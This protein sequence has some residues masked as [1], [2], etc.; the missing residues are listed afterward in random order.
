[1]N[2]MPLLAK[3]S[4][5]A[6]A[7]STVWPYFVGLVVVGVLVALLLI[8]LLP[9]LQRQKAL[10][11]ATEAAVGHVPRVRV[12]QP[13]VAPSTTAITLPGTL[14][15][16]RDTLIYARSSGYVRSWRVDLGD[17]VKAGDLLAEIDQPEVGHQLMQ[18]KAVLE[19]S[20]ANIEQAKVTVAQAM[21]NL[22]RQQ[23][24][25]P[26]M[27][28]QQEIDNAQTAYDAGRAAVAVAEAKAKGDEADVLR[29]EE[30]VPFGGI[31]APFA[32]VIT[33]R[34][35]EVGNLVSAGGGSATQPLYHLMQTDQVLAL[36][37]IPQA[38]AA[39]IAIGQTA[40][41]TTRGSKTASVP[42]TVAH[43]AR[44]LDP[45]T[46]TM[47]VELL[48]DNRDG[49]LMPGMYVQIEIAVPAGKPLL[50]IGVAS[51]LMS[52][53]GTRVAV[54]DQDGRVSL[55]K[56]EIE[57]DTGATLLIASG[58]ELTDR[59]VTNPAGQLAEGM[60]V[61]VIADP[62]AAADRP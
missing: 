3:D 20:R 46:R 1:M 10:V 8:G 47:H 53:A 49:L 30:P 12:V 58:L 41:I 17:Q 26:Q 62:P 54:V 37:D 34:S 6:P 22:R 28:S 38:T 60:H 42:A 4:T 39:S 59:V 15:A 32:G 19:Q 40:K 31:V 14:S 29:L 36:V 21:L 61:E 23:G 33:Q 18:V 2:E 24:L 7:K 51:L 27:T 5:P 43:L 57:A 44:A 52:G 55:K 50:S 45:A 25:G 56:V 35:I 9:R 16:T 13:Q 48:A 11:A